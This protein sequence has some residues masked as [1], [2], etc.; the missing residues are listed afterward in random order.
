MNPLCLVPAPGEEPENEDGE[1]PLVLYFK[2]FLEY[3]YVMCVF[4]TEL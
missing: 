1:L 4:A 3:M 2:P